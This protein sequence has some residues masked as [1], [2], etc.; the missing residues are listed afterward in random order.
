MIN[1]KDFGRKRP[2][3]NFMVRSLNSSG[4]TEENHEKPQSGYPVIGS[5][6]EL[7]TFQISSFGDKASGRMGRQTFG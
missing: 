3:F 1:W 5:R 6:F 7:G 4:G 2:W